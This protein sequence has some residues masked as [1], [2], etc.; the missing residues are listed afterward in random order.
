MPF[1]ELP[2]DPSLADPLSASPLPLLER[3]LREARE[4]SGQQNPDAMAVA[5]VDDAGEPRA[6]MVLCRG[7]D[8]ERGHLVFYT[9]RE[10]AKGRELAAQPVAAAVFHWDALSR[11]ARIS[12][13]VALA[14]D[15]MS[16]AY[17][18]GR[19]RASQIAAWASRQSAPIASRRALLDRLEAAAARF[20]GL[21][22][23]LPVP[24][25]PNWGGYILV[26][27]RV[28]LWVGSEGRAHDRAEWERAASGDPARIDDALWKVRRL[29]P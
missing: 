11:Q 16:D 10:S 21:E 23:G 13:P 14:P 5:T 29:Q 27:R 22:A 12:G 9:H 28:E 17:F 25:P 26:A 6:R 18:A 7:F 15:A 19:P 4:R 2:R 24:R 3:W 1:E 8:V 20:G